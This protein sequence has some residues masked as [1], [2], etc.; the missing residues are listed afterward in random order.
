LAAPPDDA[1]GGMAKMSSKIVAEGFFGAEAASEEAGVVGFAAGTDEKMSAAGA[2]LAAATGFVGASEKISAMLLDTA[3]FAATLASTVEPKISA[4][5]LAAAGTDAGLETVESP[6]ISS[7][8]LA[9]T[10]GRWVSTGVAS[11]GLGASTLDA[12]LSSPK[13]EAAAAGFGAT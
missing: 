12:G 2:G 6:K 10:A 4:A 8:D 11:L 13:I 3:G 7:L 9:E 5:G 1:G